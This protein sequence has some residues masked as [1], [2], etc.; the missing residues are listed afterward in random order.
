VFEVMRKEKIIVNKFQNFNVILFFIFMLLPIALFCGADI[1]LVFFA[2]TLAGVFLRARRDF[3][4]SSPVTAHRG[5][6]RDHTDDVV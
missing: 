3:R 5:R 2:F 1:L 4:L 6:A